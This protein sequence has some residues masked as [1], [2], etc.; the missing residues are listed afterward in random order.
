MVSGMDPAQLALAL[1]TEH[2]F[3]PDS[4]AAMQPLMER[5]DTDDVEEL[6]EVIRILGETVFSTLVLASHFMN[7]LDR[8]EPAVPADQHLQHFAAKY[9]SED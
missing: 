2:R 4:H 1:L 3:D 9:Q 7:E 8:A 6:H 5:A